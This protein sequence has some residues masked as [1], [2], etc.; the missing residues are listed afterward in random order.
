[1]LGLAFGWGAVMAWAAVRNELET[2]MWLLFAATV[3]WA[4]A[5]DTI[6]A[7]QDREDDRLI[8]VKSSAILFGSYTWLGVGIASAM[9]LVCL[10]LAGWLVGLGSI[11]YG[12]LAGTGGF[13]TQQVFRLRNEVSPH[14]IILH[15]QTTCMGRAGYFRW[16]S[17]GGLVTGR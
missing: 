9:M 11:F 4:I 10:G 15:V 2:P 14:R 8:G 3:F 12:V 16:D 7:L 13:L 1:M 6:Y 17:V 5:Y